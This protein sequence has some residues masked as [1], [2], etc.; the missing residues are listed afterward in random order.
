M[1]SL[2][3]RRFTRELRSAFSVVTRQQPHSQERG[4]WISIPTC[5]HAHK[6]RKYTVDAGQ[7]AGP[8]VEALSPPRREA[9]QAGDKPHEVFSESE[10]LTE[11]LALD[12][13][14]VRANVTKVQQCPYSVDAV[15]DPEISD[16]AERH[17]EES[18][19]VKK[20]PLDALMDISLADPA[21]SPTHEPM[22]N[23]SRATLKPVN[24][25]THAD[26]GHT[27][28]LQDAIALGD[29][30]WAMQSLLTAHHLNDVTFLATMVE[31][32]FTSL[33]RLTQPQEQFGDLLDLQWQL[34]I[35]TIAHYK[36]P[37]VDALMT[38]HIPLRRWLVNLRRNSAAGLN[39]EQYTLLLQGAS[40]LQHRNLAQD[41]WRFLAEDGYK[42]DVHCFNAYLHSVLWEQPLNE[43]TR[44]KERVLSTNLEKRRDEYLFPSLSAYR[45]GK[46]GILEIATSVLDQMVD[47]QVS[48]NAYTFMT[49]LRA[50]ALEGKLGVVDDLVQR[51]WGIDLARVI[52]SQE[53]EPRPMS[54]DDPLYPTSQLIFELVRAYCRNND[55]RG[56][57]NLADFI[58]H[59]YGLEIEQRTWNELL[60]YAHLL[61][62]RRRRTE[63]AK[64][65]GAVDAGTLEALWHTIT[66]PPYSF[67][68]SPYMADKL[69][70]SVSRNN[71]KT[72]VALL[73]IMERYRRRYFDITLT[74]KRSAWADLL[75]IR[76]DLDT[77]DNAAT[78]TQP[79]RRSR[80]RSSLSQAEH[81]YDMALLRCMHERT[82]LSSW[83]YYIMHE[84]VDFGLRADTLDMLDIPRML[85]DWKHFS[86]RR[87]TYQILTGQVELDLGPIWTKE[88]LPEMSV[89]EIEYSL[90]VAKRAL[91]FGGV[92][93]ELRG[94]AF[95]DF[96][97][98]F[99]TADQNDSD[100]RWRLSHPQ[101][102]SWTTRGKR[103]A[104]EP[105]I[106]RLLRR[107]IR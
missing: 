36:L 61:T 85:K 68:P 77:V 97:A 13:A 20:S 99:S 14:A 102:Q 84:R 52:A 12:A 70:R 74:K 98:E 58:S 1:A 63:I 62:K 29:S 25:A 78:A 83:F 65:T 17:V 40:Y 27:R 5:S 69:M 21:S 91:G 105:Q 8:F 67:T 59:H 49:Y 10:R 82:L 22:I 54:T 92:Q 38:R 7:S 96:L 37:K 42:P 44:L 89:E 32:D 93:A 50:A 39:L 48:P 66:K 4:S 2:S 87:V 56:A 57:M 79:G 45:V 34:R 35:S 88:D 16:H 24:A 33:L 41:L 64:S 15:G 101:K 76:A 75:A 11:S 30:S 43:E 6:R 107:T 80:L 94:E 18:Q 81:K 19:S 46:G 71:R 51:V 53:T 86:R 23:N 26:A 104:I 3:A 106:K 95:G 47:L 73:P 9:D 90:N 28:D 72:N 60:E 100:G 55:L 31:S 103:G